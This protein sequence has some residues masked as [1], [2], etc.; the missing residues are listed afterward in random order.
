MDDAAM[1]GL[2]RQQ[3]LATL[4]AI[5]ADPRPSYEL[6]GQRVQWGDYLARLQQTVEWCDRQLQQSEPFEVESRGYTP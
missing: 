3:T 1:I 4:A 6:D 5:T 2:I